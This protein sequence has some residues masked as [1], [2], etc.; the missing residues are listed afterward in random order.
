MDG[1]II[2]FG[3]GRCIERGLLL[4]VLVVGFGVVV[5]KGCIL[6]CGN[7]TWRGMEL[8]VGGYWCWGLL[9]FG[10]RNFQN[11]KVVRMV[12]VKAIR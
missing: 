3:D 11:R 7:V 1:G 5:G 9:V 12:A 8:W 6:G 4:S 10:K 2:G